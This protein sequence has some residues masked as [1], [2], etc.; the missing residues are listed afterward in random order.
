MLMGT[1]ARVMA[2][3]V[4]RVAVMHTLVRPPPYVRHAQLVSKSDILL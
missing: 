3:D 1:K 2:I 4:S